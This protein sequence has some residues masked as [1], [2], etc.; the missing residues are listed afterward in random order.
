MTTKRNVSR[1]TAPLVLALFALSPASADDTELLLSSAKSDDKPNV[2]FILDTS[3]SMNTL[4]HTIAFYDSAIT[5]VGTCDA[6]YFYW[7]DSGTPPSCNDDRRAIINTSFVCASAAG[8]VG[9]VGSYTGIVAQYRV[10]GP[11]W[12]TLKDRNPTKTVE[13]AADSG[14][15]G[16]GTVGEVY[17]K[18]GKSGVEFTS[19]AG[20]EVDWESFPTNQTYTLY[21]GNYLNWR[22][23]PPADDITRID[24]VKTVLKKVLSAYDEVNL[25]LMRFNNVDGGAVIHGM[26]DLALNRTS[27]F[28][29]LDA[30]TAN[31][32]TPLSETFYEAA[33]Y[34]QG[35]PAHYGELV[36]ENPTD[37]VALSVLSPEVYKAPATVAGI[38]PRNF[39]VLLTDGLPKNDLDT[40]LLV[41]TL[42]GWE[43]TLGRTGC[44]DFFAEGDCLDDIAEYLFKH[45]IDPVEPG[46]QFVKTFGVGFLTPQIE[47]A[48]MIETAEI[49]G[50]EFLL[51][52]DPEGLAVALLS[53]FDEI[54][55]QSLT[56]VAPALA[57][58][59]FN[60]A[61]N[62]NDLYMSVFQSSIA[63][64]WPGN[65]KKY[66]I[67][68]AAITD[69]YGNLAVDPTT[70]FLDNNAT[71]FWTAGLPDG[72]DVT[73]GGAANVLPDPATRNLYTNNGG[74]SDLS[75]GTNVLSAS[76]D[77][78]FIVDDFGLTGSREEP[79]TSEIIRWANGE[80]IA[81]DD[82]DRTTTIRYVMGDPL[83]AQPAAVDYGTGGSSDVIVFSATNDG[84]LHAIDADTGV[85]LWAFV[86]KELLVNFAKLFDNP[87]G[88]YKQYGID[89]D[90]TPVIFDE[91]KNGII[92]GPN[93]FVYIVF[94]LRRGG[95]SYYALDVTNQN[96]PKLLWNVT[97]PEF[98]QSWSAPVIAKIDSTEPGL[99]SQQAV[100]VIGA[101]YDSTHDTAAVPDIDDGEGAG[102]FMLDLHSG[103]TIWRAG[104]DALA[105]LTLNLPGRAMTR[106]FPTAIK[107]IDINGDGF[108]DRLYAADVGGQIWRF[109]I[110]SGNPADTLVTGGIIAQFGFEGSTTASTEGPR[111]IYN[112]PD[113]ALFTDT[114]QNRRFIA[115]NIGSGYRAHPLNTS[116]TDRFYSLRDP[117]VFS[118]LSQADYDSYVIATDADMIEISGQTQ[119]VISSADR[120]WR[121]TLPASQ[122]VLSNATTFN[123]SVFFVGFSPEANAIVDCDPT[124]GKNVLYEV[125]VVNGDPI[126]TNLDALNPA[127]SDA[128]R[129]KALSQGGI[130][131]APTILFPSPNENCNGPECSP[132][133]LGCVGVEC[134]S[135]GFENNPVRTLWT[136]DGIE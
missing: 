66:R 129:S 128:A 12:Q 130:A 47:M 48:R 49:S 27:L 112:S 115:I 53:I 65:L 4:E 19:N 9:A 55:E 61:Q 86:P 25:S 13:C 39:N 75:V 70:G 56:F 63:T 77:A 127:D 100:V 7:S 76:N 107:I 69:A 10:K 22:A 14:F 135:P 34:W 81:D 43:A 134:F 73:M 52:Q 60:R 31:G 32:N 6:N 82:G 30:I 103:A 8:Q 35:L 42:P 104:I 72:S 101:G 26:Q 29:K 58:N 92:D 94:G 80:D 41:P 16:S 91:D 93:D 105:N 132:P 108:A 51:A 124:L 111:R 106:A 79:S 74:G 20:A 97:Y 133:P 117:N 45:D 118:Q 15:H 85:E 5:Y 1:L 36:D 11:K 116:A 59:A 95:N 71:S 96:S 50:G 119:T 125:S 68:D 84:Y 89:G 78:A 64:H 38:C 136:Q 113:I 87:T 67:V 88:K 24:I 114:Q 54:T 28:A 44:D 18:A 3:G 126:V 46:L 33:L 37:P 57:V 102:I 123:N 17:A 131:P 2:N 40:P 23:N 99:N 62:L 83:H 109:D 110:I 121:F 21:A 98:G 90:I 120:G 122:M